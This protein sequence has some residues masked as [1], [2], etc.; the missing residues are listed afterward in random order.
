MNFLVLFNAGDDAVDFVI[1]PDESRRCGRSSSTPSASRPIAHPRAAGAT[2]P[3]EGKA[4]LVLRAHTP[5][6]AE[7]ASD[8]SVAASLSP[9]LR[10]RLTARDIGF[11]IPP[12]ANAKVRDLSSPCEN[13]AA[14]LLDAHCGVSMSE[15]HP[16]GAH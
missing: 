8:R 3:V 14:L 10:S 16:I 11:A 13:R 6:K 1:P 2:L 12:D 9:L 7:L 15:G 5:T 4:V